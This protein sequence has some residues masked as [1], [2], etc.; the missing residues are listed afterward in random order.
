ML[1]KDDDVVGTLL[2][3]IAHLLRYRI[4]DALRPFELTRVAWLAISLIAR[5]QEEQETLTQS[6]LAHD[7]ELGPAATGKLLDR[8]QD[9]GLIQRLAD[10]ADRRTHRIALTP[11]AHALL[12]T[13]APLGDHI[14]EEVLQDLPP[15]ERDALLR[16]LIKIKTRLQ[17]GSG[18][19]NATS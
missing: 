19:T 11:S 1:R 4:D 3:D 5:H 16:S 6:D 15:G 10:P 13:L 7:L 17:S 18:R 2:H 9:R 12:E 8:L 14:R